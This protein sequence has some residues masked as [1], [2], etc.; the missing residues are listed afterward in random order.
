M[1]EGQD[2]HGRAY[3]D[4]D[5]SADEVRCCLCC[6]FVGD[7]DDVDASGALQELGAEVQRRADAGRTIRE[8]PGIGFGISDHLRE[9]LERRIVADS[10]HVEAGDRGD[11]W[12]EILLR[13]EWQRA[14]EARHV[15]DTAVCKE[16]RVAIGRRLRDCVHANDAPR[17][18][19][20]VDHDRLAEADLQRRR[21]HAR[22]GTDRS[23]GSEG[24]DE[25]NGFVRVVLRRGTA[26]GKEEG[27]GGKAQAAVH[28]GFL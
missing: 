4:L 10:K 20:V 25:T 28:E 27:G 7:V 5:L 2:R 14:V 23:A 16:E 6:A 1:R 9:G 11:D 13:I 21:E 19:A 12:L 15:G 22:D 24:N 26:G 3:H 8:L 18:T 17:A